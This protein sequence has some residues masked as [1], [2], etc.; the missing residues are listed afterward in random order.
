M[1]AGGLFCALWAMKGHI[2]CFAQLEW[3]NSSLS[4]FGACSYKYMREL[5]CICL[6][7][8]LSRYPIFNPLSG[9]SYSNF[10]I[11]KSPPSFWLFLVLK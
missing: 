4:W 2:V 5:R 8:L 1:L 11:I 9:N 3:L 6:G 10:S 7:V